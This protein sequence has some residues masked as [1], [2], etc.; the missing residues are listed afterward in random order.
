LIHNPILKVLSSIQKHRV[1]ALLMGGQA[2]V[3]YGAAE[4]SRGTDLAIL[5]SSENLARL[6][7]SLT[8]LKADVIAVP[9]FESKYL[10]KGHAVH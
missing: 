2:C 5:A 1:R 7:K 10:R 9:P 6:K 8:D 3:F 4:F